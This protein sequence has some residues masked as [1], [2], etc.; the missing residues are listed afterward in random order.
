MTKEERFDL[1]RRFEEKGPITAEENAMVAKMIGNLVDYLRTRLL[2]DILQAEL[3]TDLKLDGE[4]R[5]MENMLVFGLSH[6]SERVYCQ[7]TVHNDDE[8]VFDKGYTTQSTIHPRFLILVGQQVYLSVPG[9]RLYG[10]TVEAANKH[11]NEKAIARAAEL[12]RSDSSDPKATPM[13]TDTIDTME[14]NETVE[15]G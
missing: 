2:N 1:I 8:L 11:F 5:A 4:G 6:P 13:A 14:K 12:S 9:A 3:A 10:R 15:T 7:V